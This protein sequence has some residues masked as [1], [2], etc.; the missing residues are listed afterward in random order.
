MAL[1]S[2]FLA[3]A[4]MRLIVWAMPAGTDHMMWT[5]LGYI[6]SSLALFALTGLLMWRL[7]R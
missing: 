7:T 1:S 4:L 5:G 6:L 2:V 3:V